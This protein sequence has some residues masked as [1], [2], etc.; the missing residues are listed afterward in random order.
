MRYIFILLILS[1]TTL[2]LAQENN[3]KLKKLTDNSIG[4]YTGVSDFHNTNAVSSNPNCYYVMISG[5]LY[6]PLLSF[7]HKKHEFIGGPIL[8]GDWDRVVMAA[9]GTLSYLYHFSTKNTH[10]F[11]ESNIRSIRYTCNNDGWFVPY[12][13][14]IPD[15]GGGF[16][17]AKITLLT[18]HVA[19]GLEIK[20][21]SFLFA[22]LAFGGGGYWIDPKP[23]LHVT[24]GNS[25]LD[26]YNSSNKN[27]FY[28]NHYGPDW[29]GRIGLAWRIYNF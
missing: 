1:C 13:Q 23:G 5:L 3:F 27:N 4:I 6:E 16:S 22:Q 12:N 8:M 9:G 11:F 25:N 17:N 19:I 15:G 2:F 24:G 29:Y 20:L 10:F 21:C 26:P 7:K 14:S 18:A 28:S